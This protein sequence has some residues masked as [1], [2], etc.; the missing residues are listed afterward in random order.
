[1]DSVTPTLKDQG[2]T[3]APTPSAAEEIAQLRAEIE[4]LQAVIATGTP[5]GEAGALG[6]T[7]YAS[8]LV[9]GEKALIAQGQRLLAAARGGAA[10]GGAKARGGEATA[11]V[12]G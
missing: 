8:S 3:T 2:V 5:E 11:Q 7:A 1:M 12:A 4:R 10:S 6:V 9:E